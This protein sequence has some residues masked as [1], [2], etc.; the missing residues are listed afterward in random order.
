MRVKANLNFRHK[1]LQFNKGQVVD[2][3]EEDARGLMASGHM[4][5]YPEPKSAAAMQEGGG[6]K[7]EEPD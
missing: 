7:T 3:P 1:G 4:A 6:I 5:E 2:L